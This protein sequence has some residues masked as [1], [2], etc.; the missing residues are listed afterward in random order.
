MD[1]IGCVYILECS[2]GKFYTGSTIG[3]GA[4]FTAKFLPTNLVYIEYFERIDLAFA[5]EK[6]IQGWSHKKKLALIT[7]DFNMLSKLSECQNESHSNSIYSHNLDI[8]KNFLEEWILLCRLNNPWVVEFNHKYISTLGTRNL[9]LFENP[10]VV[11]RQP[12][13]PGQ[14]HIQIF[15]HIFTI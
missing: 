1:G 14:R 2:N 10:R 13:R 7:S 8:A 11:E 9:S 5:R 3:L 15:Y 6:Q 4:N 12:K